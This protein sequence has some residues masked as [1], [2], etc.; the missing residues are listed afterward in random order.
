M[1]KH[2][3]HGADARSSAIEPKLC[4]HGVPCELCER[5]AG[6]REE[7]A[8]EQGETRRVVLRIALSAV[9]LA[10]ALLLP[11]AQLPRLFL[12]A[13]AYLLVGAETLLD[14]GKNLLHGKPLDESLLMSIATIGAIALGEYPEAVLVMLLN[15]VGELFE[16]YAVSRS[17]RAI[18][19]LTALRPEH[20]TVFRDGQWTSVPPED[21]AVGERVRVAVGERVPLD[22]VI[23]SGE[24]SLDM[25]ALTGESVPVSCESGREALSGCVN[26]SGVLEMQTTK[27]YGE[28]TAAR[29]LQLVESAS[30][31]KTR[32]EGF[33]TRFARVYTP[34]V[35][36]LAAL[37]CVVPVLLGQPFSLWLSRALIFLVISCPCALVISVPLTFFGGIGCASGHGVL[38]KGSNYLEAL[39]RVGVAVLDKTG[40]LTKG[41]FAVDEIHEHGVSKG[42]LLRLAAYGEALS[43][44]PI[45]QSIRERFGGAIDMARLDDLREQAG[46]GVRARLDGKTLLAGGYNLMK[47]N[48]IDCE[49]SDAAG[50]IVYVA[51]DGAYCGCLVLRD[52]LKPDA[53]EAVRALHEQGVEKV[54][55]LTG[56]SEETALRIASLLS[57]DEA[58]GGLLPQDKVSRV[59]ALYKEKSPKNTLVFVGDG[60]NDAPVLARADVGVAMGG[61]GSDAAIEAADV[62]IMDD[63]PSK[64]PLAVDIARRTMRIARQNIVFALSVKAVVMALGVLGIAGMWEAVLADV[65]VTVLAV[66][67]AMRAMKKD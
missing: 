19:A 1:S 26:L 65:G 17:K 8:H 34:C 55:M 2:I 45:A 5:C 48:S 42:E 11:L 14:A 60:I 62:V 43:T 12:F 47:E 35:V 3:N 40:T 54:V 56:D 63:Q 23:L 50:T 9:L 38:V 10:L 39:S 67:N 46:H 13:A 16:G 30:E 29:V 7:H 37:L 25:S 59:D 36:A 18:T 51:Y 22:G 15:Q 53:E 44:H 28:S 31:R 27:V 52:T 57:L 21:V 4:R 6:E 61:L 33:I 49:R 24:S 41:R 64:L 58:V 20:T 32:T 66:L